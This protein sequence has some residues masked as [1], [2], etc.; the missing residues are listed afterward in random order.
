MDTWR[1]MTDAEGPEAPIM[2]FQNVIA[3][4]AKRSSQTFGLGRF[5]AMLLATTV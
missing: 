1:N 5:V 2:V 4:G 3:N